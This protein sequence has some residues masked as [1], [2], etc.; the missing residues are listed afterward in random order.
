MKAPYRPI[1][2]PLRNVELTSQSG[3]KGIRYDLLEIRIPDKGI[4][5]QARPHWIRAGELQRRRRAVGLREIAIERQIPRQLVGGADHGVEVGVGVI[6]AERGVIAE[7]VRQI[8]L[9]KV[10]SSAGSDR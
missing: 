4:I 3:L 5:D 6:A 1:E 9:G 7:V 2:E 8:D 10:E